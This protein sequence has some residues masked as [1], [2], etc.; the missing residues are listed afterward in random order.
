[1]ASIDET[2]TVQASPAEVFAFVTDP[3]K[4]PVWQSSLLEARFDPDGPL[5]QGTRITETRKLLGRRLE[6]T[7]EVTEL[8]PDRRFSGKVLSGP[9]PWE[10]TYTFEASGDG[11]RVDFHI[12]GEPGGFFRLAEPI[13]VRT[14]RKQME[15]DFSTLK[16]LVEST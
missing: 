9:F 11:T 3:E 15:A 8:E 14:V 1:V 6:S 4:G 5:Q 16:E 12:E 13:V 2:V 10:F 7:V